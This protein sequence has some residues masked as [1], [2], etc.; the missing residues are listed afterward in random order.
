[1]RTG[2]DEPPAGRYLFYWRQNAV[3]YASFEGTSYG[4]R[5]MA[6]DGVVPPVFFREC[7]LPKRRIH[8]M[9]FQAAPPPPFH[10]ID[11]GTIEKG[12]TERCPPG[13]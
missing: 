9:P 12:R 8:R 10:E 5:R 3:V 7:A 1:V 13:L 6:G 11:T 4:R 2:I